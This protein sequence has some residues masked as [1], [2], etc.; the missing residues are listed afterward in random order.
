MT[1]KVTVLIPT[2]NRPHYLKV[3]IQSVINQTMT[4]WELLV[5]N[6]GGVNVY[7]II[8][9]FQD[10][11]ICYYNRE[12]N[13]GKPVC[14]NFGL[15][16]AN[17]DYIAYLD[18]DDIW[19]PNHL[20]TL[21]AA[22]DENPDIGLVY[23]DL[24]AVK[25]INNHKNGKRYPLEK[26]IQVCRD[27]NRD[28]MFYFNHTLHVSLLHRR[29]LALKVGG[30]DESIPVLV[31]WDMT[32]K[33][34]FYT[35]FKYIPVLT[36]EYYM[37]INNPDRISTRERKDTK[38]YKQNLRKIK[39]DFPPEP[40]PKVDRISTIFPV[41][42]W[43]EDII[44]IVTALFDNTFYP[45]KLIIINNDLT[46][47]ETACK[48]ALGEIGEL[49]N[50]YIYTPEKVLHVL[51]AYRFGIKK[52]SADYVFLISDNIDSKFEARL[53]LG[54]QHLQALQ[55]DGIKW[56]IE[57]EMEGVNLFIRPDDFLDKTDF[58]KLTMDIKL[59]IVS[60]LPPD[61]YVFD[62]L[63]INSQRHYKDGNYKLAYQFIKDALSVDKGGAGVPFSTNF[64][65]KVCLELG[66]YD[67]A[68]KKCQELIDKGYGADNWVILGQIF[69]IK[70]KYQRAVEAYQK[71]LNDIGLKEEDLGSPCFPIIFPEE[72]SS[73]IAIIGIGDCL[74][75]MKDFSR[76]ARM[77]RRAA[78]LMANSHRP[79]L[80]FGKLF[81]LNNELD[82]AID[83]LTAALKRDK[84]DAES[85]L[86]LGQVYEKRKK[87]ILAYDT[88]LKAIDRDKT[89]K[90]AMEYIF[91]V[92]STLE[93][94]LPMKELFEEYLEL[95]PA[96]I[97]A[98][99]SLSSIYFKLKDYNQ[100]MKMSEK[101]L[102][103]DTVN[104]ALN[105]IYSESQKGLRQAIALQAI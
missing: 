78:K 31:D 25:C 68:E 79:F 89:D 37:P 98:I 75:E 85:C 103:F 60:R 49:N 30:Y 1:P 83:A 88:Y 70:K 104:P 56:D 12:K 28:F 45:F 13:M 48:Q 3:A 61:S 100:A 33:L 81:L 51:E 97:I 21:S 26:Y 34:A 80:G 27:F 9:R 84:K 73:F 40:W 23:S 87:F 2:Y 93:K 67:L 63:L 82:Q 77:F 19:Y 44:E 41:N 90:M 71:G 20:A 94:W 99:T 46:M 102:I 69:Q 57:K 58:D 55:C 66:Y 35:D 91:R 92:G 15:K 7:D 4:D 65:S 36:G 101:G 105:K 53:I 76:A 42:E 14:L 22:L 11:R 62:F 96:D 29:D 47:D 74:L 38:R 95:R 54:R 32:R 8:S 5:M 64:Y 18:D 86:V 17:S 72:L 50:L 43:K 6:D 16:K 39:A 52:I 10:D 24:Y 59:A